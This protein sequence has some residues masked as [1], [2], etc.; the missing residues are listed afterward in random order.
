MAPLPA[1][2]KDR[3]ERQQ[4]LAAEVRQEV[5]RA[6]VP[7]FGHLRLETARRETDVLLGPATRITPR[8]SVIDWLHAPLAELFFTLDEGEEYEL[9]TA[10]RL[11]TGRVVEKNLVGFASGELSFV[12]GGGSRLKVTLDAAQQEVVDLHGVLVT[13]IPDAAEARRSLYVGV[14]RATHRLLLATSSAWSPLL[15]QASR[16]Q[17]T[18]APR[19]NP[20]DAPEKTE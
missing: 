6:A 15:P 3:L 7:Y 2:L 10:D 20:H 12:E 11:L 8:L 19:K 13:C 9:D 18:Q 16:L 17:R 14:T 1:A 5:S 4:R